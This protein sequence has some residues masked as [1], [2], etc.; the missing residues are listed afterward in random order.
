MKKLI[1]LFTAL[2]FISCESEDSADDSNNS[3]NSD[4]SAL[5]KTVTTTTSDGDYSSVITEEY[6]YE[7]NKIERKLQYSSD[8]N[9]SDDVYYTTYY[10]YANNKISNVKIYDFDNDLVEEFVFDYDSNGNLSSYTEEYF[11][12]SGISS[13]SFTYDGNY[14][15]SCETESYYDNISY[16]YT[17]YTTNSN[18]DITFAETVQSCG[19]SAQRSTGEDANT[20]NIEYDSNPSPFKNIEGNNFLITTDASIFT[21]ADLYGYYN[22]VTKVEWSYF[23][24]S[25]S[26]E[27]KFDYNSD[28]YPRNVQ[29]FADGELYESVNIE[30][31]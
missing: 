20:A 2:I 9:N 13:Y 12:Y 27:L 10:T 22:N 26:T 7:G 18:G 4:N 1:F 29:I 24:E 17:K 21:Y 25:Y 3:S 30:Y 11:E 6:F 19:F 8:Y 23:D 14:I 15:M 16:D 5:V 28:N 31:Y